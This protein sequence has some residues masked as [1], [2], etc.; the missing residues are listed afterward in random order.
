MEL[1][2][3]T[4]SIRRI[5][6]GLSDIKEESES[7][8]LSRIDREANCVSVQDKI[9]EPAYVCVNNLNS[10]S[11]PDSVGGSRSNFDR[12]IGSYSILKCFRQTTMFCQLKLTDKFV[13]SN[14]MVYGAKL[15]SKSDS[16]RTRSIEKVYY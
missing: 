6:P 10:T 4:K 15:W 7:F 11:T 16:C 12:E 8:G 9:D 13:G 14:L 5:R 3:E 2:Q 1:R